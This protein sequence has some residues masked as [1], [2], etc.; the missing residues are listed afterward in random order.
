MQGT[1]DLILGIRNSI[2]CA[3]PAKI[4]VIPIALEFITISLNRNKHY[5]QF[6][7]VETT[8]FSIFKLLYLN[9]AGS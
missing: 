9:L 2:S 1:A 3:W 4:L 5:L 6:S 7:G 8:V